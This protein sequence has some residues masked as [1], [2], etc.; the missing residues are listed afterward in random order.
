MFCQILQRILVICSFSLQ[1]SCVSF[2]S[3]NVTA[4]GGK[5]KE[6]NVSLDEVRFVCFIKSDF[7]FGRWNSGAVIF[8]LVKEKSGPE[9]QGRETLQ[10]DSWFWCFTGLQHA[11]PKYNT[12]K[13][14]RLLSVW[15]SN[16]RS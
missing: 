16:E 12:F 3:A 8:A 13:K 5:L 9:Q 15:L 11:H 1:T 4:I 2:D 10:D 6:F 7:E 14:F